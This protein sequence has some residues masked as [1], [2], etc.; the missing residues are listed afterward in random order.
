MSQASTSRFSKWWP[1]SFA[2][3]AVVFFIIGGALIGTYR[4]HL[5]DDCVND[6]YDSYYPSSYSS[7]DYSDYSC[8]GNISL[9]YGGIA[10]IAIGGFFELITWILFGIWIIKR[11]HRR[12]AIWNAN[13]P[14]TFQPAQDVSAVP[15]QQQYAA[16]QPAYIPGQQQFPR[17]PEMSQPD[18]VR[19]S[20]SN[21]GTPPPKENVPTAT[22][23]RF[24]GNCGTPV[25]GRFCT[26]CG[27]AVQ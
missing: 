6:W 5:Y 4:N 16:P 3:V 19:Q 26:Q 7:Y 15:Q 8:D 17:S 27:T 11:I 13:N 9:W 20:I 12:Q 25:S 10:C 14:Q 23:F 22:A 21:A 24:C 2:I 18:F 1:I